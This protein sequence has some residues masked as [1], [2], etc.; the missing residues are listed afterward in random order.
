MHNALDLTAPLDIA[1]SPYH[2]RPYLTPHAGRF[3]EALVAAIYDPEVRGVI[4]R[5]GF[6]GG[7]D[8]VADSVDL[9]TSPL[10][11]SQLRILYER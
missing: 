3:S 11:C 1:V 7:V 6:V 4:E 5:A 2:D 8:Q 9:L 10:L